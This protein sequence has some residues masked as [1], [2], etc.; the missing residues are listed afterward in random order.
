MV[1]R[2]PRDHV[3]HKHLLEP[4]EIGPG[5]ERRE[6]EEE[7]DVGPDDLG[8]VVGAEDDGGG[9]EVCT[10]AIARVIREVTQSSWGKGTYGW[11]QEGSATVH[12]R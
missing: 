6:D 9:L 1:H 5:A 3:Q 7:T 12:W 10:R 8:P 2:Q 11:C 4:T